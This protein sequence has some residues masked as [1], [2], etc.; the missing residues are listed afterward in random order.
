MP[1]AAAGQ[2][3]SL[4]GTAQGQLP[5]TWL[6][7]AIFI[8]IVLTIVGFLWYLF[9]TQRR[10]FLA[11]QE[12][13]DL[14]LF[15]NTPAGLPVGTIRSVLALSI[16]LT[17]LFLLTLTFF[18][19]RPAPEALTAIL[20]TVLG[21]YFG[22]RT[23]T[24]EGDEGASGRVKQIEA[25]RDQAIKEKD[26]GQAGSMI[27]KVEKGITLAKTVTAVLPG[28]MQE[29]YADVVG[30]MEQGLDVAKTLASGGNV[31]EAAAKA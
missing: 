28:S 22:S 18:S 5:P 7:V 9:I 31:A 1:D 12:Q 4:I 30:K 14:A 2:A 8:L 6:F 26:S 29:K 13:K 10:F 23:A 15:A 24:H 3:M 16:V 17:G 20:G 19:S 21:F 25:E 27:R 11:C